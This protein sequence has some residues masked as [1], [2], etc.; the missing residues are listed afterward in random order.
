MATNSSRSSSAK[1][2]SDQLKDPPSAMSCS[3]SLITIFFTC[4][5]YRSKLLLVV[6]LVRHRLGEGHLAPG[7][8]TWPALVSVDP[9][10]VVFIGRV[11][12]SEALGFMS[13]GSSTLSQCLG[14]DRAFSPGLLPGL[15]LFL[16]ALSE[17]LGLVVLQSL[18]ALIQLDDG[19]PDPLY[20]D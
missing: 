6:G 13:S 19:F 4:L 12:G 18:L 3:G 15:L 7:Y 17:L 11:A 2:T 14:S 8:R 5:Q 1:S 20:S 9:A 10:V 16:L